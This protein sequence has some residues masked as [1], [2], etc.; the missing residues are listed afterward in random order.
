MGDNKY[1][2]NYKNAFIQR[3][4]GGHCFGPTIY[5]TL[6]IEIQP[7][8]LAI[9][10]LLNNPYVNDVNLTKQNPLLNYRQHLET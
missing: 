10:R 1:R 7:W 9:K 5:L 3:P 2:K 8:P 4:Q 6:R